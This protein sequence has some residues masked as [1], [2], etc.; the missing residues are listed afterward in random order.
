MT[1][2]YETGVRCQ[3]SRGKG[4]YKTRCQWVQGGPGSRNRVVIMYNGINIGN[5]Y[6]KRFQVRGRDGVWRTH[7]R[8]MS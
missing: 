2:A 7:A 3:I 8:C 6:N 1:D 5:G 4:S